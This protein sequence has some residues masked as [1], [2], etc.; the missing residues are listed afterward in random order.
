M[1]CGRTPPKK[2]GTGADD[3]EIVPAL[4]GGDEAAFA[5]LVGKH[6]GTLIRIAAL[7][8]SDSAAAEEVAQETWLA[9]L[10]GL[11]HFEGRSSL[12][13]WIFRIL[14]NRA[15]TRGQRDRRTIPFA[16]LVDA[17]VTH[18]EAAL[19]RSYFRR[20]GEQ[21][22]GHWVSYPRTWPCPEEWML[23]Q[24]TQAYLDAAIENLPSAQ[25]AV[26]ILRDVEGLG[27]VEACQIL[28]LS[29]TNQRVLLHRARSK[30][31]QAL[32]RYMGQR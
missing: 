3:A 26:L 6:H 17:E 30:V 15:R 24:E 10:R 12:E 14:A 1:I 11:S 2:S 9:V 29:Q 7:Y 16:A 27:A 4:R 20:E 5:L 19:E 21:Y 22:P 31:R 8:V 13:T 28:A 18:E 25:R 23:A 32:E